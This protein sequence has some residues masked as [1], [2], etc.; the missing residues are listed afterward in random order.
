MNTPP[1]SAPRRKSTDGPKN[2]SNVSDVK[3]LFAKVS[4]GGIWNPNVLLE[5]GNL[6]SGEEDSESFRTQSNVN[7]AARRE[8]G[9]AL[10]VI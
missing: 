4:I 9:P 6:L 7:I 10:I 5:A 3:K 1:L 8:V 2:L